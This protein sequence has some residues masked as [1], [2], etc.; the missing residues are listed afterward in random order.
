M[1][2]RE[3]R[4][5][6]LIA[7]L[8]EARQRLERSAGA[9]RESLDVRRR[10][11]RGVSKHMIGWI[12]GATI[13]GV[14]LASIPRRRRK[15]VVKRGEKPDRSATVAKSGLLLAVAKL[16]FDAARP[17]LVKIAIERLKPMVEQMITRRHRPE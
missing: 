11:Q 16:A 14:V 9:V 6:E 10:V 5:A 12:A 3:E 1:A 7:A 13:F 4:K 2:G 15:V 8:A 17:V